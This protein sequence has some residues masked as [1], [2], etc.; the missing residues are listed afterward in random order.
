MT[1]MSYPESSQEE[2]LEQEPVRKIKAAELCEKSDLECNDSKIKK[3]RD[4]LNKVTSVAVVGTVFV[5]IWGSTVIGDAP[6]KLLT[7]KLIIAALAVVCFALYTTVSVMDQKYAKLRL[8]NLDSYARRWDTSL[9]EV[10]ENTLSIDIEKA[11]PDA[12]KRQ[13]SALSRVIDAV[14]YDTLEIEKKRFKRKSIFVGICNGIINAVVSVILAQ[15]L[16]SMLDYIFYLVGPFEIM[17]FLMLMLLDQI[18]NIIALGVVIIVMIIVGL[19]GAGKYIKRRRAYIEK[20]MPES[21][22]KYDAALKDTARVKV[23][24]QQ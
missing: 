11:S 13:K 17:D 20:N 23:E 5:G 10:I 4:V 16:F 15:I 22:Q 18:G 6:L 2:L 9:P 3:T 21:L 7:F 24:Y 1:D 8:V 12:L 14:C 19:V